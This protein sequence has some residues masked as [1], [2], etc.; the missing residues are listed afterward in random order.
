M[1]KPSEVLYNGIR[2][3]CPKTGFRLDAVVFAPAAD[4]EVTA[5][6]FLFY[7]EDRKFCEVFERFLG[8]RAVPEAE[9]ILPCGLSS[10]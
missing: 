3:H 2:P 4:I 7:N 1:K 5:T 9:I 10:S 8:R 6:C